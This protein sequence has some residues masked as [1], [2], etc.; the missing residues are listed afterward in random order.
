MPSLPE[1]DPSRS[2]DDVGWRPGTAAEFP[3]SH[4]GRNGLARPL[5]TSP[6]ASSTW[7]YWEQNLGDSALPLSH[8]TSFISPAESY[9]GKI[10]SDC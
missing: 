9:T 10:H 8:N 3:S 6:P 2:I 4:V 7:R 1:Q 5:T